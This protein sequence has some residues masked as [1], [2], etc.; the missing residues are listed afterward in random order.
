[1]TTGVRGLD[2]EQ[3]ANAQPSPQQL[4]KLERYAV[5]DDAA[6]AFAHQG[7]LESSTVEY[8]KGP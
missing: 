8:P 5:G 4:E 6:K 1:M 2:A 3:L 7:K